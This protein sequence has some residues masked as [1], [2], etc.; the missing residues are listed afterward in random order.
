MEDSQNNQFDYNDEPVEYCTHCLSLAIRDVNNQ[1]YC[2]ECG[3][4]KTD[5][6]NIFIWE[7]KYRTTYGRN[8]ITKKE[9]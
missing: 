2:D 1:P 9:E 5:K 8:Y 3:C 7:S 6:I 4:T